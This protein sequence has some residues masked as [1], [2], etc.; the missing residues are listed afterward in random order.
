MNGTNRL[1][2]DLVEWLCVSRTMCVSKLLL[3]L[4]P[5]PPPPPPPPSYNNVLC[6]QLAKEDEWIGKGEDM[7]EDYVDGDDY[8]A[9]EEE[10]ENDNYDDEEDDYD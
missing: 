6:E 9:D 5:S 2:E 4:P 8:N 1:V 7:E 10:D 3:L